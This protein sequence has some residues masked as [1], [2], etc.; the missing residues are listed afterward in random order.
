MTKHPVDLAAA[1]EFVIE[2]AAGG[3]LAREHLERLADATADAQHEAR[4]KALA[5]AAD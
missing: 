5:D 2:A 1:L 3:Q 4:V